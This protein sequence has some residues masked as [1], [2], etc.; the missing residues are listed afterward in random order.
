LRNVDRFES[1]SLEFRADTV[2]ESVLEDLI[3]FV[4]GE[5]NTFLRRAPLTGVGPARHVA[6]ARPAAT[7]APVSATGR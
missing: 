4:L 1:V 6:A 5:A 3:R 2:D 7:I